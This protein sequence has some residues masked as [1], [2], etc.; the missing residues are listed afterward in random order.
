MHEPALP[1]AYTEVPADQH[2]PA[3]LGL[4]AEGWVYVGLTLFILVAI[5]VLKAP[6]LIARGLDKRIAATRRDLDEARAIRAEAEA[7]LVD[8]RAR[9][10]EAVAEARAILDQAEAEAAQLVTKAESDI[11]ALVERRGRIAN[12]RIAAAERAAV[13]D[14]RAQTATVAAAAAARLIADRHD[15]VADKALVDQAIADLAGAR[16]H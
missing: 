1:N 15:A 9:Q 4:D 2:G 14:I 10:T 8:A 12:D 5:F 16:L 6:Q 3:L 7:L 13:A 11:A